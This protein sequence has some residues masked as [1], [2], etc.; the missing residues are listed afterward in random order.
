MCLIVVS[1]FTSRHS[2]HKLI[3]SLPLSV[4]P[5]HN[6]ECKYEA[7]VS[8]FECLGFTTSS[9]LV[10]PLTSPCFLLFCLS[11]SLPS[12]PALQ[13]TVRKV[14]GAASCFSD[15]VP[16]GLKHPA[17]FPFLLLSPPSPLPVTGLF[18][19]VWSPH[20]YLSFCSSLQTSGSFSRCLP[21][22]QSCS[23]FNSPVPPCCPLRC[24]PNFWSR[25]GVAWLGPSLSS[26]RSHQERHSD[27]ELLSTTTTRRL[28]S[29]WTTGGFTDC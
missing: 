13:K 24:F 22:R 12:S 2:S 28:N 26:L 17:L 19:F 16:A 1:V 10:S 3:V 27:S 21:A 8:L 7:T 11:S 14:R 20:I 4:L 18:S 25:S 9:A 29:C 6:Q 23:L 15:P 5:P